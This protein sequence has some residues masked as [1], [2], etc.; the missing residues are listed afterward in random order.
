MRR[1]Y[2]EELAVE[3]GIPDAP[4]VAGSLAILL[5]GPIVSAQVAGTPERLRATRRKC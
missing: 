5:E 3:A 4:R 1:G 2:I